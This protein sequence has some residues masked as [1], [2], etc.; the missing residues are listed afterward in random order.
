MS[1]L[2]QQE[3]LAQSGAALWIAV[4]SAHS[5]Q[6]YGALVFT[7]QQ[8]VGEF[9]KGVGSAAPG[10]L[11]FASAT[12]VLVRVS[13]EVRALLPGQGYLASTFIGVGAGPGA[14]PTFIRHVLVLSYA[15]CGILQCS[16][17]VGDT[18][19]GASTYIHDLVIFASVGGTLPQLPALPCREF[20]EAPVDP[21][22]GASPCARAATEM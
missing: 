4:V 5:G 18:Y 15:L 1:A 8:R 6:F 11:K 7:A 19:N 20:R 14:L 13:L 3:T 16:G 21:P 22:C 12:S 17:V 9:L 2:C 10:A